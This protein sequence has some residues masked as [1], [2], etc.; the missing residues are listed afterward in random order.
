M[1][2]SFKLTS[3]AS[4]R[5]N[6][7]IQHRVDGSDQV[8]FTFG[9]GRESFDFIFDAESV[10]KFIGL[11]AEALTEMDARHVQEQAEETTDNGEPA[12]AR[13]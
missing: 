1:F 4:A 5:Q 9:S 2:E 6:C 12:N 3:W 11:A 7:P 13:A 8:E 10:R